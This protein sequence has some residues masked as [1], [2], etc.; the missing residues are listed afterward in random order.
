MGRNSFKSFDVGRISCYDAV[1]VCNMMSTR[2]Y[3]ARTHGNSIRWVA[4][5]DSGVNT[6]LRYRHKYCDFALQEPY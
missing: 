2:M 1:S 4:S 6:Y 5:R 3:T